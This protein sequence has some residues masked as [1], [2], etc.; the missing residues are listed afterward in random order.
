MLTE[1]QHS[2]RRGCSLKVRIETSVSAVPVF[3]LLVLSVHSD[4]SLHLL[5][6][7]YYRSGKLGQAYDILSKNDVKTPQNKFLMARC[8]ADLNK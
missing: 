8:C 7:C 2:W 4:E 6:T 5:A 1:M 3:S